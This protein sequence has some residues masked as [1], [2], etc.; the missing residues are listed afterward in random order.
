VQDFI[1]VDVRDWE[2]KF[3]PRKDVHNPSWLK[4]SNRI[5]EDPDF[6]SFSHEEILS[7]IYILSI[8]SQ[9]NCGK[10]LL[11]INH[12]ERAC[13]ISRQALFSSIEKLKQNQSLNSEILVTLR[14]RDVDVTDAAVRV[15]LSRVELS[16]V[17]THN[18]KV[19]DDKLA[20]LNNKPKEINEIRELIET[21]KLFGL[22][23]Y[24]SCICTFYKTSADFADFVDSLLIKNKQQFSNGLDS[25][26]ARNFVTY[27]VKHDLGLINKKKE[28]TNA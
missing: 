7:W 21:N 26:E 13:R 2:T 20:W 11:N 4:L 28:I 8:C 18:S 16:R 6:Y 22:K 9:K 3:R 17:E 1:E 27:I 12:L 24:V 25:L 15:E 5:L 23:K 14:S 10:V 19:S